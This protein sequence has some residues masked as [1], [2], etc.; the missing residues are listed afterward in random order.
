MSSRPTPA[1]IRAIE[2]LLQTGEHTTEHVSQLDTYQRGA[3]EYLRAPRRREPLVI[4]LRP[5][6]EPVDPKL[7][8][9]RIWHAVYFARLDLRWLNE[10]GY[11]SVTNPGRH[12]T[13]ERWGF[14]TAVKSRGPHPWGS[15]VKTRF[16]DPE[17][18]QATH[19][20]TEMCRAIEQVTGD[21]HVERYE[22]PASPE[23]VGVIELTVRVRYRICRDDFEDHSPAELAA[24]VL[25]KT[26][27][28][29]LIGI[30]GTMQLQAKRIRDSIFDDAEQ[31]IQVDFTKGKREP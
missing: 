3:L 29:R 7:R 30:G 25:E 6:G 14:L 9:S 11:L 1:R 8:A 10:R 13:V 23:D 5:D 24:M 17:W 2:A 12:H 28:E 31:I 21:G 27:D 20:F 16:W 22:I 18:D 26:G 4:E 19:R 15:Q